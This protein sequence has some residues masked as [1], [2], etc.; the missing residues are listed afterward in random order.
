MHPHITRLD[1]RY[2]RNT[3]HLWTCQI[4]AHRNEYRNLG[5]IFKHRPTHQTQPKEKKLCGT[6]SQGGSQT[7]VPPNTKES[8]EILFLWFAQWQIQEGEDNGRGAPRP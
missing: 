4:C 7:V 2:R 6:S 1:Y 5:S 8:N 3:P